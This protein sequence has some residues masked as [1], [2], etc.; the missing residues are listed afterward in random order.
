MDSSPYWE[1]GWTTCFGYLVEI[2]AQ[3]YKSWADG[4][5]NDPTFQ[6]AL[7]ENSNST[8][9]TVLMN[10]VLFRSSM[11]RQDNFSTTGWTFTSG[12]FTSNANGKAN[13]L[14]LNKVYNLNHR[15]MRVKIKASTDANFRIAT[16]KFA[17]IG[18]GMEA[19]SGSC[20]G[21]DFSAKKVSVYK[22]GQVYGV[23]AEITTTISESQDLT[24]NFSTGDECT[25]ELKYEDNEKQMH[26]VMVVNATT[27]EK[28]IFVFAP[29]YPR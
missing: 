4:L 8:S 7:N 20:F 25:I 12:K 9:T 11:D 24:I 5:L 15:R 28:Q 27:G 13:S 22:M 18:A 26:T 17:N 14:W 16:Q 3:K 23:P 2:P 29:N 21:V 19:H 6:E 1:N 10:K